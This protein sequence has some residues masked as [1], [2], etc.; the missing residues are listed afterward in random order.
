MSPQS[1]DAAQVAFEHF[2]RATVNEIRRYAVR[3]VG[4]ELAD[5]VV[6]DTFTVVWRR[7]HELSDDD[8]ERRAW[9]YV[10]AR[11]TARQADRGKRR[12]E[13]LA[14]KSWSRR[15]SESIVD[16]AVGIVGD[17]HVSRLLARLPTSEREAMELLIWA[18]LTPTQ[19]AQVL[20]CSVTA[21]ST[22]LT[23]ARRHLAVALEQET[24]ATQ[25]MTS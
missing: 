14:L 18:N 7:W 1:P 17:D 6:S 10:V 20:G 25:E 8:R 15:S 19:A 4:Q 22:R 12:R 5:D 9:L 16:P 13:R 21:L 24:V 2:F 23:R 11:N 3:Q